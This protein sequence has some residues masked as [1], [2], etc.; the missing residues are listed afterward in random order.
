MINRVVPRSQRLLEP[1]DRRSAPQ[2][3]SRSKSLPDSAGRLP[4][5]LGCTTGAG[6][7]G[8][9][10]GGFDQLEICLLLER[11]HLVN[12]HRYFVAQFDD[13]AAAA[14]DKMIASR[15][16]NEKIVLHG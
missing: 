2:V 6:R 13:T 14:A 15:F 3:R 10:L 12:L 9:S 8:H 7:R 11:V 16:K 5:G 4:Q 1:A